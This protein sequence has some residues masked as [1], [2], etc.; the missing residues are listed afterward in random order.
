MLLKLLAAF[1]LIPLVELALLMK[2]AELTSILHTI[3]LVIVT[4]IIG[5]Y[6]ARR[7]GLITLQRFRLRRAKDECQVEKFRMG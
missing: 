2:M 6:L 7:E 3:T 1:I 5:S 4:G